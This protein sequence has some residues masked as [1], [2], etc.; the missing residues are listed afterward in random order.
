EFLDGLERVRAQI[1]LL[2]P[3]IDI[4]DIVI[5]ISEI[6]ETLEAERNRGTAKNDR[7]Q[8]ENV[9]RKYQQQKANIE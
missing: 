7:E 8:R 2:A 4:V 6:N 1:S 9:E 3:P 5:D